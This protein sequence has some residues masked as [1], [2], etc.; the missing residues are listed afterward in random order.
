MFVERKLVPPGERFQKLRLF[1]RT[2]SDVLRHFKRLG[3]IMKRANVFSILL[4]SF[5]W[6]NE[7]STLSIKRDIDRQSLRK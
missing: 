2:L 1:S 6:L 4:R 7:R 3:V 5:W